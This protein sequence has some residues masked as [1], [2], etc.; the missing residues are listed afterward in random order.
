MRN[1]PPHVSPSCQRGRPQAA[2]RRL[3]LAVLP[4]ILASLAEPSLAQ[5]SSSP[6]PADAPR[7]VLPRCELLP[8]PE[9]QVEYLVAGQ[10]RTRWHFGPQYPRPFF[11]PLR[12]PS[13]ASLTRM[14]HPGAENH[15]HHRSVWFAHQKVEGVD[16]WSDRTAARIRQLHW[17]AYRD[18]D[19]ECVLA[20]RLGWFDEQQHQLLDQDVVAAL[21][22]LPEGEQLLE[23][24]LTLRPGPQR[25][26][27]QLQQT[28]FGI[29]AVRVAKSL[30][31][32]FG[33]GSLRSSEGGASER[34][35]FGKPARWVDY[36]GPV[37]VGTGD[38]RHSVVEG[39][40]YFDH[41]ANPNSPAHWHV[42]EDGWMGASLCMHQGYTVK[43]ERPLVLRY[44][45]HTH[46][47]PYAADRARAAY[48][49]FQ[50]RSGFE[51]V[52]SA[53]KHRQYEVRRLAPARGSQ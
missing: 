53:R 40:T 6:A 11:Y 50:Q 45:L 23:F 8:L 46:R 49:Q 34:E 36:S 4:L 43:A 20:C 42:R 1:H 44:L 5:P 18:G 30:S 26:T 7:F 48:D 35:I 31:V 16:F 52:K 15:D 22:P 14:G 9:H 37:A 10:P 3:P 33:G 25:E 41:P 13:G 12:G 17:Y 29:L 28:N 24:Q 39:I 38:R 2:R 27:V 21:R 47:G 19:E 32:H 51:I